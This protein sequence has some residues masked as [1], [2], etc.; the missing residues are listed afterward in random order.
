[1]RRKGFPVA[2]AVALA[3]VS[4]GMVAAAAP[5]AAA[6]SGAWTISS[7]AGITQAAA[8]TPSG[9]EGFL[10]SNG[11]GTA[12]VSGAGA[13][14]LVARADLCD[15]AP[16]VSVEVDGRAVGTTTVVN[17]VSAG[18]RSYA[19]GAPLQ[20]GAH[21]V[22]VRFL[23]DYRVIGRCDRNV[24]LGWVDVTAPAAPAAPAPAPAPAP[25]V[26]NGNPFLVGR[27]YVDPRYPSVAAAAALRQA[28][29]TTDAALL[30]RISRS[31]AGIWV[32]DWNPTATVAA[33]TREYAV[34]ANAAGQTG[35]VVVYAI[36]GRDCGGYSSGGLDPAGYVAWVQQVAAGLRGTRTAVVVEP[37][38]IPQW[39]TCGGQGDRGALL[40][41]AVDALTA[42]GAVVYLDAGNSGWTGNRVADIA[43]RLRTAGVAKARGFAVNVSNFHTD[44]DERAYAEALVRAGGG[45]R[46]VVDTSRNGRGG[47]G[48][49]CNPAGRALGAPPAAGTGNRDAD[50]WIKRVGESDGTCNGGPTAGGWFQA[51]A[52]EMARNAS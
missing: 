11:T 5:A 13:L 4:G 32:G 14:T 16:T 6:V 25:A 24:H 41:A 48:E 8:G 28:G 18:W 39:G 1:M 33:T 31:T 42:A 34:R 46:Y 47:N 17:A 23:N 26:T 19:V 20:A 36:P 2:A 40:R 10:W 30:D 21:R 52:L 22:V 27:P 35:V 9:T 45:A 50:L 44:A 51:Q 43:S 15:G 38:A 29:R 3:A 37:D 12:T 7:G 49:W